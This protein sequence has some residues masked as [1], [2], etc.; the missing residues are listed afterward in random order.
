MI[1]S[2]QTE[3]QKSIQ[4]IQIYIFESHVGIYFKTLAA[5]SQGKHFEKQTPEFC[6]KMH[7]N[8]AF[9]ALSLIHTGTTKTKSEKPKSFNTSIFLFAT[10]IR[11]AKNENPTTKTQKYCLFNTIKFFGFSLLVLC[12]SFS[13]LWCALSLN[14][15]LQ[16]VANL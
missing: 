7:L 4:K 6:K 1:F 12:F 10:H 2:S 3:T 16:L 15:A 11:A 8:L 5:E 14:V 9:I 13:L